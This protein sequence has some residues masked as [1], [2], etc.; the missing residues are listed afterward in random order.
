M[1]AWFD[2]K[3]KSNFRVFVC[4]ECGA[5]VLI[6]RRCDRGHRYCG[7]GCSQEARRKSKLAAVLKYQD[8]D[9]GKA[10][11]NKRQQRYLDR[12]AEKMTRQGSRAPVSRGTKEEVDWLRVA[13]AAEAALKNRVATCGCCGQLCRGK[14][15]RGFLRSPERSPFARWGRETA[16]WPP[17]HPGG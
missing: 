15:R 4:L 17:G 7:P 16:W 1:C 6:C 3:Q 8:S 2:G 14:A 11:H 9:E 13:R 10:N 12:E 5:V